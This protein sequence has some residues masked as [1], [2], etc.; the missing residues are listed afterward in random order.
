MKVRT[1]IK[2]LLVVT[3]VL[4]IVGYVVEIKEMELYTKPMTVPLFFMM[5]WFNAKTLNWVF[6]L[7]L[8][9]SFLGDVLLL[10]EVS[11]ITYVLVCYLC[12]YSLLFYFLYKDYKPIVFSKKDI[13]STS[14]IFV[15]FTIIVY[16]VYVLL[17][18][19]IQHILVYANLYFLILYSL[20]LASWLQY[21]NIKSAKAFWFVIA[22]TS[23]IISDIC[24]ALDR[25]YVNVIGLKIINGIYQLLAV[26]F[27]VQYMITDPKVYRSRE[28]D[29]KPL[30]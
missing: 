16:Q 13:I 30:Q 18:P 7:V 20:F 15:M 5:Y 4:S 22:I 23:Y 6:I 17:R 9:L 24:F 21:V 12:C 1:L 25:F 27:L 29:K 28:I 3:G 19:N 8:F 11:K 10:I 2:I 14:V 26:F